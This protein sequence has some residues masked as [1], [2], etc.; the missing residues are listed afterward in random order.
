MHHIV[1]KL[2]LA[3]GISD[4]PTFPRVFFPKHGS[5]GSWQHIIASEQTRCQTEEKTSSGITSYIGRD[6][7][8]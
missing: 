5:T 3:T 4:W 8:S 1:Y 6:A 2:K 7:S